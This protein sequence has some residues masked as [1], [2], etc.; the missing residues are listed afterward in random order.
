MIC[1]SCCRL[2]FPARWLRRSEISAGRLGDVV[3]LRAV[4]LDDPDL[5]RHLPLPTS[6][7][8]RKDDDGR[9]GGEDAVPVGVP[10]DPHRGEQVGMAAEASTASAEISPRAELKILKL[11]SSTS[12]A[13]RS[14]AGL[15]GSTS[16]GERVEVDVLGDERPEVG[17]LR[18]PDHERGQLR[19]EL[20]LE[21][22][23]AAG[24]GRQ[25]AVLGEP[26]ELRAEAVEQDLARR[27]RR[28]SFQQATI[29]SADRRPIAARLQEQAVP[30][31]R[32]RERAARRSAQADDRKR[33]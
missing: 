12:P 9:V 30:G 13:P 17:E 29:R 20:E 6:G 22:R 16:A 19:P 28:E 10:V 8:R 18:A 14:S 5:L 31:H 3:V 7:S 4:H 25:E 21:R 1:S 33:S 11:P 15:C 23:R 32:G 26:N 27:L 24:E 2:R